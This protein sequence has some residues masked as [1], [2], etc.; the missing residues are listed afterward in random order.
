MVFPSQLS[1]L[2]VSLDEKPCYLWLTSKHMC[3]GHHVMILVD[4]L[5]GCIGAS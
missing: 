1:F 4:F 3:N 2:S 5:S